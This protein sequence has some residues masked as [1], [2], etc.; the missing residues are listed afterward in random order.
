MKVLFVLKSNLLNLGVELKEK[1]HHIHKCKEYKS[2]EPEAI[3][4]IAYLQ[5]LE[6]S[7]GIIS[8]LQHKNFLNDFLKFSL[9]VM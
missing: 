9:K 4:L 8:L 1:V 3:K 2:L 5:F 6:Y 7:F